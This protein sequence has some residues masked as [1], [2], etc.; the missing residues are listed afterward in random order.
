MLKKVR[1]RALSGLQV[2][3]LPAEPEQYPGNG[4]LPVCY[5]GE[6]IHV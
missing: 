4:Y 2:Q 5:F 6:L 1:L 3:W